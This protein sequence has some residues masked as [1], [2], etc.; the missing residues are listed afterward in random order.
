MTRT[1]ERD[2]PAFLAKLFNTKQTL[3]SKEEWQ[4]IGDRKLGTYH[5]DVEGQPVKVSARFE[6]E[7]DGDGSKYSI[8]FS[9]KAN[10]PMVGKKVE[11]F[12]IGQT[13]EGAV[14]ELD[15]LKNSLG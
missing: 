2:L 9:C 10:I 7:P 3:H 12:I 15:Y 1:V 14:K 8:T 5:V 11:K 4:H 6:L 13:E